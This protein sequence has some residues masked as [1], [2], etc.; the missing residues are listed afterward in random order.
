M[1]RVIKWYKGIIAAAE[2]DVGDRSLGIR[3]KPPTVGAHRGANRRDHWESLKDLIFKIILLGAIPTRSSIES[4][5][6]FD[7]CATRLEAEN[8]L[9][10]IG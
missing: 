4:K 5:A 2:A 8:D 7:L 3:V 10:T 6:N 1:R 9:L